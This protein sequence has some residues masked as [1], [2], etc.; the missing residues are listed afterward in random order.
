MS[1]LI[2]NPR[3]DFQGDLLPFA[4]AAFK[5]PDFLVLEGALLPE[6]LNGVLKLHDAQQ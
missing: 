3:L 6:F 1:G 5:S 4:D 2:G